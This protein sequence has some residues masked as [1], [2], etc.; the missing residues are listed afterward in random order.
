MNNIID[1]NVI[2]RFKFTKKKVKLFN[3]IT[4]KIILKRLILKVNFKS[5]N[6]RLINF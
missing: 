2:N 1:I 6:N 5:F 4:L 3:K